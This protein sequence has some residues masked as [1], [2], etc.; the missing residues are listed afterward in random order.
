M[1]HFTAPE[2][3]VS[4]LTTPD[5]Q[6]VTIDETAEVYAL[7]AVLHHAWTGLPPTAYTDDRAPWR[8]KLKDVARRR[9]HDLAVVRPWPW[10]AFENALSHGLA[11]EPERRIPSMT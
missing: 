6:P 1:V 7:A 5:D 10:P 2:T 8:D 4:I 9:R 11:A 3:A